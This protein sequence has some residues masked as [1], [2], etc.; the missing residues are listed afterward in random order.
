M[1]L[2]FLMFCKVLEWLALLA[3]GSAAK[4][5]ELLM[6]RDEVAVWRRQGRPRAGRLGG[7]GGAGRLARL[8]PR[9]RWR[10]RPA[11]AT[12]IRALVL[13]LARGE[14]SLVQA[15]VAAAVPSIHARS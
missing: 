7:P 15:L 12:G 6:L 9:P 4:D 1:G 3:R 14:P 13:R 2:L 11:M 10:G 5:A 8:L